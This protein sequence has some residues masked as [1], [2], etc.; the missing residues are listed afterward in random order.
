[1]DHRLMTTTDFVYA[2]VV[3]FVARRG[4]PPTQ[5]EIA[6]GCYLTQTAVRYHLRKLAAQKRLQLLP[7]LARGIMLPEG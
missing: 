5:R 7:R 6:A 1:M 2:Y 3:E 4:F